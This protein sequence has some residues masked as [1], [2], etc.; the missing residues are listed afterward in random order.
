MVIGVRL[1]IS[2]F[3]QRALAISI[4]E[5]GIAYVGQLRNLIGILNSVATLGVFNGL[6]KYVSEFKNDNE[7]LK[8]VFSTAFVFGFVGS[9]V[10]CLVV[11][12]FSDSL[13]EKLFGTEDKK[14]V[15]VILAFVIPVLVLIK[16]LNGIINGLSEYKKYA[17]IDLIS[18]IL[19]VALLLIFLKYYNLKG[20]LL[21]IVLTPLIQIGVIGY[22]FGSGL[23][24]IIR[25]QS[26]KFEIPYAKQLLAFMLMSLVSTVVINYIEIDLRTMIADK[27][28]LKEA[29]Y[30]T[31][32]TFI[33]KNY[34]VFSSGIFS[35]YVIPKF[36]KIYNGV[37]FKK[38][39]IYIYKTLIP[40]FG[41]GMLSV[42][43]FREV[44]INVI[45]PNFIGMEPLFK[46]QLSGDFIR[47]LSLVYFLLLP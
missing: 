42:Y 30:W 2:V 4:G 47:L 11:F 39:V 41:L 22:V 44:V 38:E 33:S 12:F 32:M 24:K 15:I 23:K 10:T 29:G 37:G 34:M 45:Y 35:L 9:V 27:I 3:V 1:V 19:S 7:E 16:F 14:D 6:I 46:W 18:Y 13:S 28:S 21:A 20:V 40:I 25:I 31:A 36:A 5:T 17:K 8:K 26:V 43:V